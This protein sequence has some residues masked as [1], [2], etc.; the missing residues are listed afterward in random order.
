MKK[1]KK[2]VKQYIDKNPIEQVLGI[3][4]GIGREATDLGKKV[5]NS[6]NW[7]EILGIKSRKEKQERKASGG[8]LVQ[9]QELNLKDL[10]RENLE[11][12]E[13]KTQ[14][15]P[16][17]DYPKEI[18]YTGE[19]AATR[20][21]LELDAQLREIAI[22]IKKL[23]DSSKELQTQ[24]KDVAIKQ[25]VATPGKYHKSFFSWI[26][27]TIQTARAKVEDSA[28]WLTAMHSKKKQRQYGAM[29]KKYNTS[30]TLSNERTVATQVG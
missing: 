20:E 21:T 18:A 24:F 8:D 11:A 4:S 16:A 30:F 27:S 25:H 17:I 7:N 15:K 1:T 28:A 13:E 23:T 2:A 29:A 26:L 10:K 6:D 19:R 12:S 14:I 22:Q 5:I 9:G 3:G